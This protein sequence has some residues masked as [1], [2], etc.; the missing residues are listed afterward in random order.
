[1]NYRIDKAI[2]EIDT[3]QRMEA[4]TT[5]RYLAEYLCKECRK[6]KV[7]QFNQRKNGGKRNG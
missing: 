4:D 6:K 7:I 1:M 3:H 2:E 5:Y